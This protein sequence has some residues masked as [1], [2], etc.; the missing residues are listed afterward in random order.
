MRKEKHHWKL[1]WSCF[2]ERIV[3]SEIKFYFTKI[4]STNDKGIGIC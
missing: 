3:S 2:G 1:I 4:N